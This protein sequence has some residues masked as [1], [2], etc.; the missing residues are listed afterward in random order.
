MVAEKKRRSIPSDLLPTTS[1]ITGNA[2]E[3]I[4]PVD[5]PP[6][7][8]PHP[9]QERQAQLDEARG[10]AG[11]NWVSLKPKEDFTNDQTNEGSDL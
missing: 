2:F 4:G 10:K 8:T 7:R 9:W 3:K 5:L 11:F 6:R 1:E